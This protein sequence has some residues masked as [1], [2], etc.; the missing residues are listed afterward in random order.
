MIKSSNE[1]IQNHYDF[2]VVDLSSEKELATA[3]WKMQH[4]PVR[5]NRFHCY[6][7]GG[8]QK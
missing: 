6:P 5:F 2:I 8:N 7:R 1:E 4:G 3:G